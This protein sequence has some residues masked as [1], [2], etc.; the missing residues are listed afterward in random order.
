MRSNDFV[1]YYHALR[2]VYN[3]IPKNACSTVKGTLAFANDGSVF[4]KTPHEL[5]AKYRQEPMSMDASWKRLLILRDPL[6]RLISAYLDKIVRPLEPDKAALVDRIF[7]NE[8]GRERVG[9]ESITLSQF[10][11]W[12]REQRSDDLDPHWRHQTAMLAF[13]QYDYVLRVERLLS[14]WNAF[15]LSETVAELRLFLEHATSSMSDFRRNLYHIGGHFI[16]GFRITSGFYPPKEC[17]AVP[18]L[19]QEV[20][21]YYAADYELLNEIAQCNSA[22]RD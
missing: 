4:E 14:D 15:G 6:E 20:R 13:D 11:R 1:L 21:Q 7:K 19:Q 18:K 10:W 3:Y 5:D 12:V 16:Y 8:Y 17:F 2:I 9:A 22:R